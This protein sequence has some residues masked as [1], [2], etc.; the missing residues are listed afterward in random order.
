MIVKMTLLERLAVLYAE[1]KYPKSFD[2]F[3][4][5]KAAYI[6]AVTEVT[7]SMTAYTCLKEVIEVEYKDGSH[8]L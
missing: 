5:T 4:A 8:Q 7:N 2:L 1:S 3:I 6:D